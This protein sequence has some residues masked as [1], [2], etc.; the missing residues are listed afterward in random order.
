V[1]IPALKAGLLIVHSELR[2]YHGEP[3]DLIKHRA[4]GSFNIASAAG[5][6]N[7]SK[8]KEKE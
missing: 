8:E 7:E 3:G 1:K 5:A 4:N 6:V 2:Q